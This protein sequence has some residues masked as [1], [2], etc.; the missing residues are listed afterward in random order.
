VNRATVNIDDKQLNTLFEQARGY[1]LLSASDE[2]SA[3]QKKWRAVAATRR[4]I[5]TARSGRNYLAD[6]S[7]QALQAPPQV[8]MFAQREHHFILRRDL[9]S[10]LN[11]QRGGPEPLTGVQ[12]LRRGSAAQAHLAAVALNWP[13]SLWMG[14]AARLLRSHGVDHPCPV[15]DGLQSWERVWPV[16]RQGHLT[17][18]QLTNIDQALRHYHEA[19]ETLTL[20]NLR[21][22]YSIAG[23]YTGNG[24]PLADLI[25]EGIIGLMRAAEKYEAS[26]GYRFST[27][28]F[29]WISQAIRRAVG[30]SGALIRY[31]THIREQ[32]LRLHAT[33][34]TLLRING[35]APSEATLARKSKISLSKTRELRQLRNV[36][37][38]L[39]DP[40]YEDGD[41]TLADKVSSG[42]P[43]SV[44]RGAEQRS[45]HN[46]LLKA[47]GLLDA[48]E[49]RVVVARWGLHSGPPL[50]RAEL[51]DS[52]S[53][54]REWV[55]QLEISALGKLRDND[56]I[57]ELFSDYNPVS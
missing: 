14:I 15:A 10:W 57:V 7:E 22:V 55:R 24:V 3:D 37:E 48:T 54:S 49:R 42:E 40:I 38:S 16:S 43:D 28:C 20:H 23:R 34:D 51:A 31:P 36:S 26:K 29:N 9:N 1:A 35:V 2:L 56:R 19:R 12:T 13:G 25:Q 11:G 4:A 21:L 47:I 53:V 6:L 33:R 8:S 30:D 44:S 18:R 50:S 41:L 27:Y 5:C 32:V 45:L 39:N 52:L 17:D 46:Q